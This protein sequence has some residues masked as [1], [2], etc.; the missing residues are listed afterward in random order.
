MPLGRL[1]FFKET[2]ITESDWKGKIWARWNDAI[3]EAGFEPDQET[4]AY[5]ESFLMENFIALM[6][7]GPGLQ[8]TREGRSSSR[9]IVRDDPK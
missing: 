3:R 9:W 2:G 5:T 8:F 1:V 7:E 4:G 6:P